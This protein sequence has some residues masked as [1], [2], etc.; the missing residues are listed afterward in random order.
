MNKRYVYLLSALMLS[1]LTMAQKKELKDAEKAVKKGNVTEATAAL[2]AVEA[3][4]G[5]ASN[6]EKAQY[7]A[8]QGT[9]AYSQIQ[10]DVDVDNNVDAIIASYKKLNEFETNKGSKIVK[11]ADEEIASVAT[12]VVGQAIE[13]NGSANYKGATRRF[14]QAYQLSPKDTVYLYY[15]ASTAINS[16]DYATAVENYKQLVDLG[17]NGSESY[18]TAIEKASG[19]VQS[20]GKDSKMRDLMVKQGTHTDPKFVKEDSKR[21]EILKN[22]VLIYSQ[23]G[24]TEEAEKAI[25]AAREANPDDINLLLTHMDLYLKSNNMG[26][27]EELAKQALAK[28][29][30]DDVLLYNLGV[31][32]FDA[33]RFEDA[34]K[35]Y[36]EA[37]RINPKSENAYLNMAFLKLQ[38]DQELTNKMNSLGMSAA[39]NKKYEQY[40]KEKHAIYKDAMNDLEKVISINPGNEAAISTLKNIYR[41]LEMTDR[42]KALE[43]KTNK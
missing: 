30:N 17:Y 29:P 2:K 19:Q 33:G 43:A 11:Q 21:P 9:L 31:T 3:V 36:E 35:Y 16:K 22:L 1:G 37:I 7:Y 23:E 24:K 14:T 10:K 40:Q 28:N 12:K 8:L 6:A 32:S 20:F 27:Y 13:D 42:L 34:R 39:D 4:L 15:A 25:V 5:N 38:P 18:Y 41:A 26:K